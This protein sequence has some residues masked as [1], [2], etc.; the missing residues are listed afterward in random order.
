MD[1]VVSIEHLRQV[2]VLLIGEVQRKFGSEIDLDRIPTALGDYWDLD[3]TE[4][5]TC[6]P[7]PSLE[8]STVTDDLDETEELLT[9]D[10][11]EVFLWHDLNHFAGI[12]R[13]LAFLD[14]PRRSEAC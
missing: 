1:R 6:A 3:L 13:L 4:A 2:W 12:L 10:P 7:S 9:R 5:F 14:L 8:M 11:G